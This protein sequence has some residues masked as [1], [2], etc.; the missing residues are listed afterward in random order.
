MLSFE[1]KILTPLLSMN[2]IIKKYCIANILKKHIIKN[3]QI[4]IY[5]KINY[6]QREIEWYLIS[7]YDHPVYK[8]THCNI[9][10]IYHL[11]DS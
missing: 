4:Y 2:G 7:V 3:Y 11:S 1:K 6:I 5:F 9:P 10:S 8:H